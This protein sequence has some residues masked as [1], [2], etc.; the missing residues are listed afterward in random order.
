MWTYTP[1]F[2]AAYLRGESPPSAADIPPSP[3]A[4]SRAATTPPP[5]PDALLVA[6]QTL[7]TAL[8]YDPGQSDGYSGPKTSAAISAFQE[9]LGEK[10]D[11]R[12][13]EALRSKLQAA[14]AE[15]SRKPAPEAG[16][17]AKSST[18]LREKVID[19][20]GTGFYV[21]QHTIVT[22]HHVVDDCS[23]IRTRKGGG[24]IGKARVI[25][26]SSGDDLAAL[27]SDI[28]SDAPLKLRVGA[29]LKPAESVLVFGYPL[30]GALSSSG[31]TTL[32]NI[33]ALTGLK[34]DSRFIQISASV[35]PGNSGGPV[36]DEAGRLVGVVEAKLDALKW[37]RITGDIPQNVNF[38]IRSS[39]LAN[40]LEANRIAYDAA[41]GTT[42]LPN[43]ELADRAER[44]SVELDCLK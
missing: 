39:T 44:T 8:G 34:D 41:S 21:G 3:A 30:A 36:L 40:F 18:G 7:L 24:E 38:A 23:E 26:A 15:R 2:C 31:N 6:I 11:G 14:V 29:P 42:L 4:P 35:Q 25:A 43:T 28:P 10:P 33:T 5:T 27:H 13:S 32:G 19:Q 12:P 9:S 1:Q 37:L 20:S 22:N 17:A 16:G